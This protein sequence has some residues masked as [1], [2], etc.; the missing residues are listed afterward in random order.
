MAYGG[1]SSNNSVCVGN[2]YLFDYHQ[3]LFQKIRFMCDNIRYQI[4]FI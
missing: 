4:I 1:N 2:I 3:F